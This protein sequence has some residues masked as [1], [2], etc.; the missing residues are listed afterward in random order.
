MNLGLLTQSQ[1]LKVKGK[2]IANEQ[3]DSRVWSLRVLNVDQSCRGTFSGQ[4]SFQ[5]LLYVKEWI[6]C[7]NG[8]ANELFVPRRSWGSVE[9]ERRKRKRFCNYEFSWRYLIL[10]P[11][12]SSAELFQ[13]NPL[14]SNILP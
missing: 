9:S 1:I 6:R 11:D 5:P 12:S 8:V 13:M 2:S 10:Q 7:R 14:H 3:M 4:P